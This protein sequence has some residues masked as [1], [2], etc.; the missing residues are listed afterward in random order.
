MKNKKFDSVKMMR[1]IRDKILRETSALSDKEFIENLRLKIP[2][3]NKH[4]KN[5]I[6]RKIS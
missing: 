3:T 4:K 1:D 5:N 2:K 6:E